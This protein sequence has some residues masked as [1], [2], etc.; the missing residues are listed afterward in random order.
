MT[1]VVVWVG[2][3]RRKRLGCNQVIW[4][5]YSTGI[6]VA[7]ENDHPLP[8][9]EGIGNNLVEGLD[10]GSQRGVVCGCVGWTYHALAALAVLKHHVDKTAQSD[11]TDA[12]LHALEA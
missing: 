4:L 3:L 9:V 5:A 11:R 7:C 10:S 2:V 6:H 12:A 8:A 1:I